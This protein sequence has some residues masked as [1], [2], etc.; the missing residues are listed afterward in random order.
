MFGYSGRLMVVLV[1][2]AMQN[3]F[4]LVC[5]SSSITS[6]YLCSNKPFHLYDNHPP[7]PWRSK[8]NTFHTWAV[9]TEGCFFELR[10]SL[11]IIREGSLFSPLFSLFSLYV[12]ISFQNQSNKY[13]FWRMICQSIDYWCSHI[14]VT[15]NHIRN[16]G[17]KPKYGILKG[18][19]L[20]SINFLSIFHPKIHFFCLCLLFC[21]VFY[22]NTFW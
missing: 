20:C 17:I 4:T 3:I 18:Y 1:F 13:Y 2:L 21:I 22:Q 10:L 16:L 11:W 8:W 14:L 9:K 5:I 15:T 7:V 19:F 12:F 6:D